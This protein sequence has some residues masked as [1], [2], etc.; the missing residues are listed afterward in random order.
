MHARTLARL[1]AAA[2]LAT[3]LLDTPAVAQPVAAEP[4]ASLG[5]LSLTIENDMFGGSDRYYTSGLRLGW[6]APA[7]PAPAPVAWLDQRMG[8]LLGPGDLRWGLSLAQEISTPEDIRRGVAN[9]AD[10]P[11]AGVLYGALNLERATERQRTTFELQ[12]GW[13]GPG[14]GGEF[15]QN[16]WHDVINKYHAE[17]W[18][19]QIGDEPVLGVLAERRWRLPMSGGGP[20]GIGTDVIPGAVV[21]LGNAR[22][23]AAAGATLRLG[24]GLERDWGPQRLRPASAGSAPAGSAPGLGWY[25]F[26]GFEGRLVARDVTLDGSTW[27]GGP[28][29][30]RKP[31]VADLNLGAAVLWRGMRLSYTQ[32]I[33]TKE[34]D[35]QRNNQV[36]GSVNLGVPF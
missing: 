17:G 32:T 9:P 4:V 3:P 28:D 29:V 34:F 30:D 36:F 11:Y 2:I 33:R 7:G 5:A 6:T 18:D 10:R 22:T 19:D 13:A 26:A 20:A 35:G 8:W 12:A 24:E 21:G 23:Y 15:V 1:A 14:A 27:R 16:R 31:G 25:V